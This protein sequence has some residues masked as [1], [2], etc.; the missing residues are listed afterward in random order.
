MGGMN[1]ALLLLLVAVADDSVVNS[2]H[3]L[4]SLGPGPVRALHENQVCIFCHTPHNAS[5]AAPL[6]NRATPQTHYRIY[7]SS[8]TDARIDQPSGASKLCLSCHD[9][10]IAPGMVLNRADP[11]PMT[12]PIMPTGGGD[13]TTDL[14]DDHPIGFRYDRQLSNRDPQLRSPDLVDHRIKLGDRGEFEC[15]ACHDPHNN[16]LG[17]FLRLPQRQGTLCLTCHDLEGWRNSSHALSGKP[18]PPSL[19]AGETLPYTSMVDNACA[20]CHVPH[21]AA[22]RE[23]LLRARASDLC[24]SCHDGL[25][26]ADIIGVMGQ[27]SGHRPRRILDRHDPDEDPRSMPPHVDCVDCHNPHA[28]RANP[29]AFA[30]GGIRA[31]GPLHNPTLEGV[32]GIDASGVPVEDATYQ[33]QVCFRC[34]ADNPVPLT[35]R[36]ARQRDTFGNVRRQFAAT[37]ASAHPVVYAA[38]DVNDAPSLLPE[39]R[40]RPF[41]SCQDC[42][43]NP[44]ARQLGGGGPNGPHGSRFEHLLVD[45]YETADFTFESAQNYALCYRCHDRNSILNDESFP[46]HRQHVVRGR[47]PCSACH[48]P[49]GVDGSAGQHSHLINFDLSI[50]GGERQFFDTGRFSGSCTLTCHGVRHV[51]FTYAR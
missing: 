10:T 32:G 45:R 1:S 38:R 31:Q 13:L 6:W 49:H 42:H 50:V 18:V 17:D 14:S 25:I 5:P 12:H 15:T 40:T 34:H 27:R 51:N 23:R 36:I 37:T 41:M 44:D 21:G 9:G 8:T 24:T 28:A 43:N 16:E 30:A 22:N 47:T 4:S 35:R 7:D 46:F 19:T 48:T 3:D 2:K 26:A 33:Y 20:T 39:L 11:I 29:L